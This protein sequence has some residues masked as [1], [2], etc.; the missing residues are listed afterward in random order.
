[1]NLASIIWWWQFECKEEWSLDFIARFDWL[2]N[3][4]S[5]QQ[6]EF[7]RMLVGS[8]I[9]TDSWKKKKCLKIMAGYCSMI[10]QKYF[11]AS[12]S[13]LQLEQYHSESY[14]SLTM[15]YYFIRRSIFQVR[16]YTVNLFKIFWKDILSNA[17]Y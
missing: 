1:M 8:R 10:V 16:I 2:V 4:E 6:G 5:I 11:M 7:P 9:V 3:I 15:F 12:S 13:F 14:D 17:M